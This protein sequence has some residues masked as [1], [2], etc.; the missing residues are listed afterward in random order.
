MLIVAWLYIEPS[1][2]K[3]VLRRPASGPVD[4]DHHQQS[5]A[6]AT[7]GLVHSGISL[8]CHEYWP[9]SLALPAQ[10]CAFYPNLILVSHWTTSNRRENATT[11]IPYACHRIIVCRQ[12][13]TY[14]G[15]MGEKAH[16][17]GATRGLWAAY[18]VTPL[19][20][21]W[22]CPDSPMQRRLDSTTV[23]CWFMIR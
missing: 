6:G 12:H 16:P 20:W 7:D 14:R 9:F 11:V 15:P 2:V 17:E 13:I 10:R 3:F 4:S 22:T 18:H 8:P 21:I 19:V 1:Q 23:S 5:P